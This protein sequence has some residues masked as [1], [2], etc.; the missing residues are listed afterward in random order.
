MTDLQF[1][2]AKQDD[3]WQHLTVQ[4]HKDGTLAKDMDVKTVMDTWTL[5]MGFPVVTV[6]R[7]YQEKTAMVT[8]E[9]FLIGKSKE[10]TEDSKDYSWWIP[11]TFAVAGNSFV[12]TYSESWMKEGE[13]TKEISE[14]PESSKAVVFNVQQTGYYRWDLQTY[15]KQFSNY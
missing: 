15:F 5:Q 7:N 10:K 6:K 3:L 14:M 1:D 4:G 8:Q 12:N 13:S 2:A 9:R 11:L